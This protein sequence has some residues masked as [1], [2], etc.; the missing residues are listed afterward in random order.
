MV[1]VY[2]KLKVLDGAAN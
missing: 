2:G 1:T